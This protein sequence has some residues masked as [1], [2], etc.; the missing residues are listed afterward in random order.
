MPQ[1][2]VTYSTYLPELLRSRKFSLDAIELT[3]WQSLA[4]LPK[5]LPDLAEFT[6]YFHGSNLTQRMTLFPGAR[7]RLSNTLR[8]TRARWFSTH[9]SLLPPGWF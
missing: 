8:L 1:L 9:I 3:P 6:L 2:G 5:I 4:S 7:A